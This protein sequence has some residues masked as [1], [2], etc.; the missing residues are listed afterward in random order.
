MSRTTRSIA[1]R[2]L[3]GV[4]LGLVRGLAVVLSVTTVLIAPGFTQPTYPPGRAEV[5][6]EQYRP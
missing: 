1:V 2:I 3:S 6:P 4:A 5:P